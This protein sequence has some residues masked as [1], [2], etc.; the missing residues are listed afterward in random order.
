MRKKRVPDTLL[1]L[2]PDLNAAAAAQQ[3]LVGMLPSQYQAEYAGLLQNNP[4]ER[5]KGNK[6]VRY[7][8]ERFS[9]PSGRKKRVPEGK[10]GVRYLFSCLRP[11][12]GKGT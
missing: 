5:K 3:Q 7:P 2:V 6:G 11:L 12:H 9:S 4:Y 8:F 10:N 1:P